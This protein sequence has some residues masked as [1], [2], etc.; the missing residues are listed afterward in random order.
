MGSSA[1]EQLAER[2]N[3]LGFNPA[4][5]ALYVQKSRSIHYIVWESGEQC[6]KIHKNIGYRGRGTWGAVQTFDGYDVAPFLTESQAIT[7][8]DK[9]PFNYIKGP[10]TR[11]DGLGLG[12][13]WQL[14]DHLPNA[15]RIVN[16]REH[17]LRTI[18]GIGDRKSREIRR[19]V[20]H[21]EPPEEWANR[22]E[23]A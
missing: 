21:L 20:G 14:V 5:D 22:G 17:T 7:T 9:R 16:A 3:I 11:R 1:V 4:L 18:P 10:I 15:K 12:T 23:E 2:A 13:A 8:I 19:A 6:K